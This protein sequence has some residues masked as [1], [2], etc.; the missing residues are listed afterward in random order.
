MK[1]V[2]SFIL[3]NILLTTILAQEEQ[4]VSEIQFKFEPMDLI[5]FS[6]LIHNNNSSAWRISSDLSL[7]YSAGDYTNKSGNSSNQFSDYKNDTDSFRHLIRFTGQYLLYTQISEKLKIFYGAGPY[8]SYFR[9][10]Q[11]DEHNNKLVQT[12][13]YTYEVI[14]SSTELGLLGNVG[15]SL[16]LSGSIIFVIE[17]SLSAG[18]SFDYFKSWNTSLNQ[19]SNM[20]NY[21]ETEGNIWNLNLGGISLGIGISF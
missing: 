18:Y 3:L 17:Y 6:Y 5:K 16:D 2:L 8:I 12:D 14:N 11:Y 20:S 1:K 4:K 15:M 10:K 7:S 13:P 21:T 9:I 19:N